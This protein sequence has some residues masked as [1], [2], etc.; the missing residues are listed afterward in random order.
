MLPRT[1]PFQS[2]QPIA[3]RHTKILQFSG[4]LELPQFAA[5]N[6]RD[7]HE[8][9]NPLALRKSFRVWALKGPDHG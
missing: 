5:R 3:R 4:D 2:F 7:V 1:I 9:L 6:S 8:P